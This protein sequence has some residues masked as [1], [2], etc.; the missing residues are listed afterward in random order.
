M[1]KTINS[2]KITW[3]IMQ[4]DSSDDYKHSYCADGDGILQL[5]ER[6]DGSFALVDQLDVV[7]VWDDVDG[8]EE[9]LIVLEAAQQYLAATYPVIFEDCLCDYQ[10][11]TD[12]LREEMNVVAGYAHLNK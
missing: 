6:L 1:S 7:K 2:T 8:F 4:G 3:F 9:F 5:I 11:T 12:E 10:P